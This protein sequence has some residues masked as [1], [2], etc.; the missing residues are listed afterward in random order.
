MDHTT[1]SDAG[2]LVTSDSLNVLP[3]ANRRVPSELGVSAEIRPLVLPPAAA[4]GAEQVRVPVDVG[5][6][7]EF[8]VDVGVVDVGDVG[9]V[10]VE[11]DVVDVEPVVGE[12]EPDAGGVEPEVAAVVPDDGIQQLFVVP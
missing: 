3:A 2:A 12:V 6:D 10:E 5:F 7:A 9:D 8:V 1:E 4:V 11:P